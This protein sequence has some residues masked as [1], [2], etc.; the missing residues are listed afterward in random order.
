MPLVELN[1]ENQVAIVTIN[2]P[3]ANTLNP[4]VFRSLEE[5]FSKLDQD[6]TKVIILT[7]AG[8]R[9]F[10]GGADIKQFEGQ[11]TEKAEKLTRVGQNFT[12]SL[13]RISKPIIVAVNGYCLGGG[14]EM[15]MAC[16]FVIA[17]ET[18]KFG[19]PEIKLGVIPGWG[20]TQRIQ[21]WM[22]PQLARELI[23]TGEILPA[24]KMGEFVYKI[25]PPDQLLTTAKELAERIA[26]WGL[27]A[28]KYAK[29]ALKEATQRT[30]EE[31]LFIEAQYMRKLLETEDAK[32]G[33]K[34][35]LEKREPKVVDK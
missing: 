12:L 2:N 5:V 10:V 23:F 17:S 19:Q 22:N 6:D 11:D 15:A 8:D 9:F 30:L 32:E 34:A 1:K 24:S 33:V 29:R 35:F 4:D 31:G 7:G 13:E 20:G 25:V 28:L 3:P 16:D 27:V 18:A 26:K 21:R 14:M